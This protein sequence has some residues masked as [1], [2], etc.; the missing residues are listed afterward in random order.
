ML[1]RRRLLVLGAGVGGA[2]MIPRA[3]LA[4]GAEAAAVPGAATAAATPFTRPMPV[5]PTLAPIATIAGTDIYDLALRPTTVEVL[6]G[7]STEVLSYARG[8]FGGPTIRARTGRPVKVQIRNQQDMAA[9][10]HLH[11]A[12]VPASSDGHPLDVIQPGSSRLYHYPNRQVGATLWYHDHT[13]HMEAE[14][15]YRGMHGFY[16]IQGTD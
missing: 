9:N 8:F 3:L 14:H 1:T 7:L 4:P 2:V 15:V 13:H 5:P 12:N 16:L 10:V 11:G 6:P